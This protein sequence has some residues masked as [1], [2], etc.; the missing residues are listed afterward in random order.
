MTHLSI[1]PSVYS[2]SCCCWR[3]CCCWI[4]WPATCCLCLLCGFLCITA[5]LMLLSVDTGLLG[6][7]P[8]WYRWPSR[9]RKTCQS[10]PAGFKRASHARTILTSVTVFTSGLVSWVSRLCT[11]AAFKPGCLNPFRRSNSMFNT[12]FATCHIWLHH[13]VRPQSWSLRLLKWYRF[14]LLRITTQ[15]FVYIIKCGMSISKLASH[16]STVH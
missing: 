10:I 15:T 2:S 1:I 9:K 13:N 3:W 7:W 8:M 16:S 11:T 14:F 5:V 6:R 4:W 12:L